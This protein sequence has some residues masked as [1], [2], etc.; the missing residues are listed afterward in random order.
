VSSFARR[1]TRAVRWPVVQA[2][3]RLD[4]VQLLERIS[5]ALPG[6]WWR[7]RFPEIPPEYP[8][9]DQIVARTVQLARADVNQRG[10]E[11][12]DEEIWEHAR[13]I[14]TQYDH[15]VHEIFAYGV[16]TVLAHLFRHQQLPAMFMS[17]DRREVAHADTMR[18]ARQKGLGIIAL[19]NH[20]SHLDEL[21]LGFVLFH[22]KLGLPLFA[23][24]QNMMATPSLERLLMTGSYRIVRKGASKAYLTTLFD[25]CRTLA[26]MGKMQGIFLEAWA[27]GARTRDG[28]L[29]Y[30]RRLITLQGALAG[31][32]DVLIQPVAI[33]YDRVP[34][35]AALANRRGPASWLHGY[36]TRELLRRPRRGLWEGL[37]G[38]Y[39]RAYCTYSRPWLLSELREMH[40]AE[41]S[42]LELD[43]YVALQSMKAVARDKKVMAS[44]LAAQ[45]LLRARAQGMDDLV[46]ATAQARQLIEDYHRRTFGV[47]PDF[48]DFIRNQPLEVVVHEGLK[49]LGVRRAVGFR[50]LKRRVYVRDE[51]LLQFYATHGDRRLYSPS[52]RENIVVIGGGQF[53]FAL[54]WL[55]GNR[56]L[57]EKRFQAASVTMY[58]PRPE[59]VDVIADHRR[60]PTTDEKTRRSWMVVKGAGARA[61]VREVV[62]GLR[63]PWR[64]FPDA[65]LPKNVFVTVDTDSAF[66]KAT[67]VIMAVGHQYLEPA[68]EA[69][70]LTANRPPTLILATRGF[71]PQTHKLPYFIVQDLARRH[72][73]RFEAV[74]TLA[75]NIAPEEVLT[76][77]SGVMILAGPKPQA[78]PLA[79]LFTRGDLE[80]TVSDDP[81]GVALAAA[82]V[83]AYVVWGTFLRRTGRIKDSRDLGR[84]VARVSAEAARLAKALQARPET[85]AAHSEVWTAAMIA[86][87][88][89]GDSVRFG[90]DAG[91]LGRRGELTSE[92]L[93]KLARRY[94]E[95]LGRPLEGYTSIHSACIVAKQLGVDLPDLVEAD[96]TFFGD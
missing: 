93:A 6:R 14:S 30:P 71:D 60:H 16:I 51:N 20:S 29:R 79:D 33:S 69:L 52:A 64:P 38:I 34:E 12:D 19:S 55:V 3:R 74:L 27:G 95:N 41:N 92:R 75:G 39:G 35:D 82:L 43:E 61:A 37:R 70:L 32:Q 66:R 22:E 17:A 36:R 78:E 7:E 2:G 4:V 96:Q 54:S 44:H 90:R 80:T 77:R 1:L 9:K 15:Q 56:A 21:I 28:S 23:A 13:L 84:Y 76:G 58:D 26:D 68:V 57:E 18:Q 72:G 40:R 5:L 91:D 89:G 62:M 59:L 50:G 47:E 31:D 73:L 85:F 10:I 25:Y 86:A 42:D 46:E 88:L 94:A 48:E 24:G 87:G 45:G 11:A 63:H 8:D 53:G 81:V 67:E 65:P 83:Q 49:S